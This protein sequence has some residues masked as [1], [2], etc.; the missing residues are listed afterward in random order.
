MKAL[1]A[2]L[3]ALRR[4][5]R[6]SHIRVTATPIPDPALSRIRREIVIS[7]DSDRPGSSRNYVYLVTLPLIGGET[8]VVNV[9]ILLLAFPQASDDDRRDFVGGRTTGARRIG[10]R[11]FVPEMESRPRD[12]MDK[13]SSAA[14][15]SAPIR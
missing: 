8:P 11:P 10:H 4:Y 12:S 6:R 7:P 14:T 2:R 3:D 15:R 9:W 1:T 5:D 13:S